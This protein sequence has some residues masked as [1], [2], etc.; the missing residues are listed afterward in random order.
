MCTVLLT[1]EI[2]FD[3][4]NLCFCIV[5][6]TYC[7]GVGGL[8]VECILAVQ[9]SILTN[10]C[11]GLVIHFMLRLRFLTCVIKILFGG[12]NLCFC[13]VLNTYCR[14]VGGL[15]VEFILA[16]QFSILTNWCRGLVIDY[17]GCTVLNPCN[18]CLLYTSR[19]V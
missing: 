11:T 9:F 1:R 12:L 4:L 7:R 14:V 10:W 19:C 17:T 5:L 2:L 18:T 13:I 3:G 16:V 15:A 6:N 8:A